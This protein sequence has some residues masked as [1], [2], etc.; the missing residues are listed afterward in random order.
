MDKN[1][2]IKQKPIVELK[3]ILF[4]YPDQDAVLKDVSLSIYPG[5]VII[6]LGPNG[7][8]KS[9]LFKILTGLLKPQT[10]T[11]LFKGEKLKYKSKMLNELRQ[12]VGMVFQDPDNQ[13]F[14]STV[15]QEISFGAVNLRLS[16]DE[17]RRRTEQA[18][19][20]TNLMDLATRAVQYL[21]FGQKKRVSV[22][23]LLVM[24]S[25]LLLLDEPT[26]WLDP[27]NSNLVT[28]ILDDLAKRGISLL[29]ATHDVNWAYSFG[30][31][32][33]MLR[34]GKIQFDGDII[35]GFNNV[36]LLRDAGMPRPIIQ[37]VC[38][39]LQDETMAND[40]P[41]P[42]NFETFERWLVKRKSTKNDQADRRQDDLFFQRK[43]GQS[44]ELRKGYT[45]GS[46]AAAAAL[47]SI[48]LYNGE[49]LPEP[50]FLTIHNPEGK[51]ITL[52][53][54]SAEQLPDKTWR[55]C[56]IKDGGDDPDVTTG[57][58][59][60]S[61]VK[62]NNIT[63]EVVFKGGEGVGTVTLPGLKIEPGEPAINPVP[64]SMITQAI[65]PYMPEGGGL[66]VE[67][68]FRR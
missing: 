15:E 49:V 48:K 12:S 50:P 67:S 16:Q 28:K 14:A 9:T 53:I 46:C 61:V 41:V 39:T 4:A 22:A 34:N 59:I 27:P 54:N 19:K 7:S 33:I 51:P 43:Q 2:G 1:N 10:G 35:E 52:E 11:F 68:A 47:A 21:S 40:G 25:D 6:L 60:C 58:A 5:E 45:T 29:I 36:E 18:I 37:A 3:D 32:M 55:C 62:P 56:V 24:E 66:T 57:L 26:A 31:R 38:D 30:D 13:L 17:V 23:D 20:D 42:R 64:R 44:G 8:G 65:L 63:G